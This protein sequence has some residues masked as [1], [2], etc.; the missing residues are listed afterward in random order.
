LSQVAVV[1][2][3]VT[4]AAVVEREVFS[5]TL[6]LEAKTRQAWLLPRTAIFL[7]SSALEDL[8]WATS[9]VTLALVALE[10]HQP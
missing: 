3:V 10:D 8:D 5:P 9:V 2:R 4:L 6:D 7:L 1:E